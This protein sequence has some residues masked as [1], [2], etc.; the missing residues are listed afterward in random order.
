MPREPRLQHL[1]ISRRSL[2]A[3]AIL[4][5]ACK[6]GA[7]PYFGRTTPPGRQRLRYV[8]GAELDSLDPAS[9]SGGFE[10]FVIPALF[11]GLTAYHPQTLGTDGGFGYAL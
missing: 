9:Y 8:L 3:A 11:E 10:S 4:T 1:A 2:C 7:D 6:M 5:A